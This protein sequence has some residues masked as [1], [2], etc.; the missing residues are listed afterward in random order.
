MSHGKVI[1]SCAVIL[2]VMACE[3]PTSKA[4][5]QKRTAA[6]A[7]AEKRTGEKDK[8]AVDA[9]ALTVADR[10]AIY[11]DFLSSLKAN[12][13]FQ[14]IKSK[15][16][17]LHFKKCA[18]AEASAPSSAWVN[19]RFED[20]FRECLAGL[21]DAHLEVRTRTPKAMTGVTL[22]QLRGRFFV[23]SVRSDA[24]F[25]DYYQ[26]RLKRDIT[27]VLK[28]GTEV[29]QLNGAAVEKSLVSIEKKISA[30]TDAARRE[31]AVAALTERDFQYS[32][33]A[34]LRLTVLKEGK[35][36]EVSLEWYHEATQEAVARDYF[37][38]LKLENVT[39]PVT[40]A[41]WRGYSAG[42]SLIEGATEYKDDGGIV[43]LRRGLVSRKEGKACYLQILTFAAD[44]VQS[45]EAR[46]PFAAAVADTLAGCE[47]EGLSL[48]LDL[49]ANGGG[50]VENAEALMQLLGPKEKSY[51]VF[52]TGLRT[53][54]F[55]GL[56]LQ[57]GGAQAAAAEQADR[58]GL[59]YLPL[60]PTGN[61]PKGA[62]F[63]KPVAVLTSPRCASA[64]EVFAS[65]INISGR[66]TLVGQP[67][68][69]AF[70]ALMEV[71]GGARSVWIDQKFNTFGVSIPNAFMGVLPALPKEGEPAIKFDVTKHL[72][73]GTGIAP[74]EIGSYRLDTDDLVGNGAGIIGKALSVLKTP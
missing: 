47:R 45:A 48:I 32:R 43:V 69:G 49:R 31:L 19:L 3:R 74:K 26:A 61:S 42:S 72:L 66:G 53:R 21:R 4:E 56:S 73:E 33:F 18:D 68:A 15:N 57:A 6:P 71:E 9:L 24:K 27:E 11:E 34:T 50:A 63:T 70:G 20:R 59:E 30:S 60:I 52:L 12:Y 23:E 10:K 55:F 14:K 41:S 13:T 2:L 37:A 46:M 17:D 28:P 54:N 64:C 38:T 39:F 5:P 16:L 25:V 40:A 1:F 44:Q 7:E 62:V 35:P 65:L 51:P 22:R 29:T 36:E 67:T 8:K 58:E